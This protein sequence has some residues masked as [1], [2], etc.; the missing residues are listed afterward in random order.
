[1]WHACCWKKTSEWIKTAFYLNLWF[2][3]IEIIGWL[4]TNSVSILSD[5][6]H[7]AWDSIALWL[8]RFLEKKSEEWA[9]AWYSYWK[10][11]L[12]L[13]AWFINGIILIVWSVV[14]ISESV[15]R[16]IVPEAVDAKWMIF[17][18]ILWVIVN[19]YAV[20]RLSNWKSLNEKSVRLH[21]LEDLFWRFAVL[22][23]SIIMMFYDIPQLD[24]IL[25][26]GIAIY[27]IFHAVKML[28]SA[29]KLFLQK[30]PEEINTIEIKNN[31][32]ELSWVL[33]IHH[34]HIRSLD[35]E[36]HVFTAH[37]IIESKDQDKIC[38]IKSW[39]ITILKVYNFEHTTI[40][41]EYNSS[42]CS[43]DLMSKFNTD[44]LDH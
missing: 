18:A 13:L 31:I 25:W 20:Y 42:D 7:D 16:L 36:K 39:I 34:M 4:Y 38:E 37:I 6:I 35:W 28:I 19:G 29:W 10:K 12:S 11:R 27:V 15:K 21:L 3:I 40:E 1:M 33:S 44:D 32:Q 24:T 9:T 41:I 2:T 23:V 26:L 14:M 5:A 8:S 30:A 22:V 17:L 43:Q